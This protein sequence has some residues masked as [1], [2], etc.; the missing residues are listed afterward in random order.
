[1]T[2]VFCGVLLCSFVLQVLFAPVG[3][4]LLSAAHAR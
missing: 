2:A 3:N 4:A 1:M